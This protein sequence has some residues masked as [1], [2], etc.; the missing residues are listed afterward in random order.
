MEAKSGVLIV[1]F[2]SVKRVHTSHP[3]NQCN[4]REQKANCEASVIPEV[5]PSLSTILMT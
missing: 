1:V 4:Q 3:S 5:S 2:V